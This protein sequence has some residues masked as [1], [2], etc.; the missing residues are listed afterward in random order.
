[1]FDRDNSMTCTTDSGLFLIVVVLFGEGGC[2]LLGF[3]QNKRLYQIRV[4]KNVISAL[5]PCVTKG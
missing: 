5:F 4:T 1:M 2:L 3:F